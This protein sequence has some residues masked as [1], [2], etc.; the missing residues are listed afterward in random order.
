MLDIKSILVR[1]DLS[2]RNFPR[3]PACGAEEVQ[4][5]RHE[6]P[7]EWRCRECRH[8]FTFEPE[9]LARHPVW[10]VGAKVAPVANIEC[11]RCGVA[12]TNFVQGECRAICATT[13]EDVPFR[14]PQLAKT[15]T[16]SA[17]V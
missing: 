2:Y 12:R 14:L 3:C 4:I 15:A 13:M 7:A 11:P 10:L 5:M 1:Q 17:F 9:P 16:A 6:Q 8:R